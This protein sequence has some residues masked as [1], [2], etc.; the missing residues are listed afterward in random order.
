MCFESPR[1][2]L[3]FAWVQGQIGVFLE[4]AR[5]RRC[6]MDCPRLRGCSEHQPN[7]KQRQH[8]LF[9]MVCMCTS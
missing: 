9:I 1:F 8:S 5:Q 6:R 3:A 4:K 7:D 2:S